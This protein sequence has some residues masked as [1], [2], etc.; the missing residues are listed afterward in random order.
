VVLN[1]GPVRAAGAEQGRGLIQ[2]LFVGNLMYWVDEKPHLG[3][4]YFQ[5]HK[6]R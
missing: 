6:G 1:L 5:D 2:Q 4:V 3:D